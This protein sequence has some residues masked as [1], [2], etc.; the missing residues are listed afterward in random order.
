MTTD[1]LTPPPTLR[2]FLIK[3]I[4]DALPD[5]ERTNPSAR[6]RQAKNLGSLDRLNPWAERVA[7]ELIAAAVAS[8]LPLAQTQILGQSLSGGNTAELV[9]HLVLHAPFVFKLDQKNP[10]LA[11]EGA[12]MQKLRADAKLPE[13]FRQAWPMVYAVRREQP[14]AYLME[15][16][17]RSDGWIS[18][19]DRLFPSDGTL[20][21]DP[22]DALRW[23]HCSLD[24]LFEGYAASVNK[25]ALPSLNEDVIQRIRERLREAA[26]LDPR[27]ASRPLRIQGEDYAPWETYL[28][29]LERNAAFLHTITPPFTTVV[30]G[31]PN[32][33]NILLRSGIAAID[34]K[35]IDPKEW[36][37][38]DYL[39]DIAKITHFLEGTG[40][41]EKPSGTAG[42]P[43]RV[44][45]ID[46]TLHI[47]Y[48]LQT[49]SW[50]PEALRACRTRAARFAEEHRDPH[51]QARYTL[52]MAANL[53][54]LPAG[55]LKN[56][57]QPRP[58]AALQLYAEGIK[59][60]AR[61]C[62]QL[63]P[64]A[65]T[66]LP[67][68]A[69]A[70]QGEVEPEPLRRARDRVRQLVPTAT[71]TRDRRGFALL[72]W[73]PLRANQAGKPAELSLEHEARLQPASA[74]ALARLRDALGAA[75]GPRGAPLLPTEPPFAA[76]RL[77]RYDRDPGP[78]SIDHYYETCSPSPVGQ[79]I[80]RLVSLRQRRAGSAFMTWN[81]APGDPLPLNLELPLATY[82]DSGVIARLEF[83]WIDHLDDA[84]ADLDNPTL[85]LE[86]R[87]RNPLFLAREI[88]ACATVALAPVIEHSTYREKFVILD[89]SAGADADL[90]H[91]NIDHVVAQSL[92]SGRIGTYVDLDIAPCRP[93]D[94]GI[95]DQLIAL[96]RALIAAWDL[97]AN[98]VPKV[99]R[100]AWVTGELAQPP[101][102]SGSN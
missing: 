48:T 93:V 90:F 84:L 61:F 91:L 20:T 28:A 14:Y 68:A 18:L 64:A 7:D 58:E 72:Q 11:A 57:R 22:G 37:Q 71:E 27:L 88:A 66:G 42:T 30:H 87:Q 101:G 4:R 53:L 13:R 9:A 59:W 16:F 83:N 50:L 65:G 24:I 17:P 43:L 31:D 63:P 10:K 44:E 102:T 34:V 49:P 15:F 52:T 56:P 76:L 3:A 81:G 51:W 92:R 35:L 19:E 54:G 70:A 25:R 41:I 75:A 21:A 26:A 73:S 36:G 45:D 1:R 38:G 47:S 74:A 82:G 46:G 98:P 77:R 99:W 29:L 94:P 5:E 96:S 39:F 80:P 97:Q 8:G 89:P 78:Q 12:L 2:Q 79:L 40:P 60:L 69:T 67:A 32:P 6:S 85:A 55:R 23:L 95:L 62:R 86:E 100:S 33:G